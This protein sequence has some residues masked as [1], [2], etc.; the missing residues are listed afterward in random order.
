M[1]RS[2][3]VRGSLLL[4]SLLLCGLLAIGV[5]T[6]WTNGSPSAVAPKV[7]HQVNA[8][9]AAGTSNLAFRLLSHLAKSAPGSNVLISPLS[10]TSALSL[11]LNGATG[12]TAQEMYEVLGVAGVSLDQLN[13]AKF[14]TMNDIESEDPAI[15]LLSANALWVNKG[16]NLKRRFLDSAKN[17]YKAQ[18]A[19]L[20]F[21]DPESV[22][23][24]NRWVGEKTKNKIKYVIGN[25]DQKDVLVITNAVYFKGVWKK[26]FVLRTVENAEFRTLNN[27][28]IKMAMMRQCGHYLYHS[29]QNVQIIELPYGNRSV[30]MHIILPRNESDYQQFVS[31]FTQ[32]QFEALIGKLKM[33]QGYIELPRFGITYGA[34]DLSRALKSLG[35]PT[36]FDP[37]KSELTEMAS[38][39]EEPLYIRNVWHKATMEVNEKGTE[40]VAVTAVPVPSAAPNQKRE[41]TF[42][43]IMDHPFVLAISER[44]SKELLFLASVVRPQKLS[45]PAHYKMITK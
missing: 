27:T 11:A 8:K 25:L 36:A 9:V 31:N 18:A 44:K 23:T 7:D 32:S 43:M 12:K 37:E 41:E 29:E 13:R 14:D 17:F 35:M 15:E 1:R 10:V 34:S 26:P 30:V 16:T 5:Q 6:L 3:S 20:D 22:S 4:C 19:N 28:R 40:A 39:V 45:A 38:N 21:S 2:I 24:I 33:M 42:D